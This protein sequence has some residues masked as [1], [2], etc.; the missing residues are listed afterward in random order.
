MG[1]TNDVKIL[2]VTPI[3]QLELVYTNSIIEPAEQKKIAVLLHPEDGSLT[4]LDGS[5]V[6][7]GLQETFIELLEENQRRAQ[8]Q[9][10]MQAVQQSVGP[11]GTILARGPSGES[12]IIDPRGGR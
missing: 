12:V 2:E 5:P 9:M 10:Q 3:Q 11:G 8:A 4:T 6:P 1:E 7:V